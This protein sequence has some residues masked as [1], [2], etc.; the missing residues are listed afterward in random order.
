MMKPKS[1]FAKKLCDKLDIPYDI[2]KGYATID[3]VPINEIASPIFEQE[4]T[5]MKVGELRWD[6]SCEDENRTDDLYDFYC[7][8]NFI[9][10]ARES[11]G[12]TA[13]TKIAA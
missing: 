3:G 13:F 12:I 7:D 5:P 4:D 6:F 9:G 8:D 1:E 11:F 10:T 2:G